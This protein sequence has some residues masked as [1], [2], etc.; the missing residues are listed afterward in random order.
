MY[1]LFI[2]I[3]LIL[4]VTTILVAIMHIFKQ[5]LI[6]AYILSGILLGPYFFNVVR[7]EEM[8]VIF[9]QLGIALLLF[10]VG[11]GL[12]PKVLKEV[13]K[14]SVITGLSQI[15]FTSI[16]GFFISKILGFSTMASIYIAIALTFSST[17]II[18]K[19]LSDKR[20]IDTLYGKISIGFL[21]VQD[22]VAVI[23]LMFVSSIPNGNIN[24]ITFA[25]T[26]I[27]TGFVLIGFFFIFSILFIRKITDSIA[28]SQ[29][30]LLLFSISW[31]IAVA[32]LFHQFGFSLEIG[33]LLAGVSLSLTTYRYEISSKMKPLRDFFIVLFFISLGA[34]MIFADIGQ[35]IIPIIV[36]SLFILIGNPLIVM[37]V[38]GIFGH[39]K[40]NGFLAGLTVAQISEFSLILIMMGI[41][42]GHLN[43]EILSLVTAIG[44]ITIAGSTYMILYANPIYNRIS[45]YLTIFEKKELNHDRFKKK[46]YN[47][48]L[49]GYNRIGFSI[50]KSLKKIN[51]NFL[52]IDFNPETISAL[53]K[54]DIPCRYGDV[55]DIELLDELP[56]NK[57]EMAVSTIPDLETNMLLIETIRAVNENA[58]IIVRAHQIKEAL[59]L[60]EKGANYVLTPHFLGGEYVA[61]MIYNEKTNFKG[62]INE[63]EQHIKM[64]HEMVEREKH[65][66]RDGV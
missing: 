59:E 18:M 17:I 26:K 7:S 20:D 11:L 34:Q 57:L 9:S 12:N 65:H 50:L 30:F 42:M 2:E 49:F 51:K 64:L 41:S 14:I 15:A 6:I 66:P 8:L 38:L 10:I 24:I 22:L 45:K 16:I 36:F 40:R 44:L 31:C 35:H 23:I 1:D 54:I 25:F 19:L 52:V 21:I 32:A 58:I 28:K 47:A 4:I 53:E 33:A 61:K 27:L 37:V 29:E 13:G 60:Y 63:K 3:G 48:I 46:K 39:T 62:Y 5:P 43:S 55:F 56:L